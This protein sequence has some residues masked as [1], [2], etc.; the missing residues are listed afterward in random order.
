MSNVT[1]R[2]RRKSVIIAIIT[3]FM[4]AGLVGWIAW[5]GMADG[6]SN[7]RTQRQKEKI[8]A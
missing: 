3:P 8:A 6:I 4:V 5:N 7:W 1:P 2:Q